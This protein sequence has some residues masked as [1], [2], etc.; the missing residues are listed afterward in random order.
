MLHTYLGGHRMKNFNKIEPALK[1]AYL[2]I[3][4]DNTETVYEFIEV[5]REL[6]NSLNNP[7]LV[8]AERR[9]LTLA[10]YAAIAFYAKKIEAV[11]A[12]VKVG[13]PPQSKTFEQLL[14]TIGNDEAGI[15]DALEPALV[16]FRQYAL[17]DN[18]A[19][20][21]TKL[22]Q[23]ALLNSLL[24]SPPTI[25]EKE[26]VCYDA[27]FN[28]S[29]Q[30]QL[31]S[32]TFW[33]TVSIVGIPLAIFS[34]IAWGAV[35]LY[36]YV[37]EERV[38]QKNKAK[39]LE[40]STTETN[41]T[42]SENQSL[43][44]LDPQFPSAPKQLKELTIQNFDSALPLKAVKKLKTREELSQI[45]LSKSSQSYTLSKGK[46]P[47]AQSLLARFYMLSVSLEQN[48]DLHSKWREF[49]KEINLDSTDSSE[50][51]EVG[52]DNFEEIFFR[53]LDAGKITL[54]N[55]SKTEYFSILYRWINED[56]FKNRI[57]VNY[58]NLSNDVKNTAE[59]ALIAELKKLNPTDTFHINDI[60]IS[61]RE[62]KLFELLNLAKNKIPGL[63]SIFYNGQRIEIYKDETIFDFCFR[64][65]LN[66]AGN[67]E[68]KKQKVVE[69]F[70]INE[71]LH[72]S[73]P[74]NLDELPNDF[75]GYV[76]NNNNLFYLHNKYHKKIK[77]DPNTSQLDLIKQAI[78]NNNIPEN[79]NLNVNQLN[80]LKKIINKYAIRVVN[81]RN[82]KLGYFGDNQEIGKAKHVRFEEKLFGDS[83]VNK[84]TAQLPNLETITIKIKNKDFNIKKANGENVED[85]LGKINKI[86]S[87][88]QS[89][90][91]VKT[92]EDLLINLRLDKQDFT[93][94]K[95]FFIQPDAALHFSN[96]LEVAS[97][98]G[99]KI[100]YENLLN[101]TEKSNSLIQFLP[102]VRNFNHILFRKNFFTSLQEERISG[103]STKTFL[104]RVM[105]FLNSE[106]QGQ[107]ANN[108]LFP[109]NTIYF[110]K[111]KENF[112][113]VLDLYKKN[114]E[115]N[116]GYPI[117]KI[118]IGDDELNIED[119]DLKAIRVLK[120]F[121]THLKL[122]GYTFND[123]CLA[124]DD[125]GIP[126]SNLYKD[127]AE[128]HC[129]RLINGE[130]D[131]IFKD[132][133]FFNS[134]TQFDI[135]QYVVPQPHEFGKFGHISYLSTDQASVDSVTMGDAQSLENI[136]TKRKLDQL[137]TNAENSAELTFV[138]NI[139]K[140]TAG[141]VFSLHKPTNKAQIEGKII[142]IDLADF[143]D[144]DNHLLRLWINTEENEKYQMKFKFPAQFGQVQINWIEQLKLLPNL[145]SVTFGN[146]AEVLCN[147]T[148][149]LL[150]A[151]YLNAAS[152]DFKENIQSTFG[153]AKCY[154]IN[155]SNELVLSEKITDAQWAVLVDF[156]RKK[157]GEKTSLLIGENKV[158][159]RDS[160]KGIDR[161]LFKAS[162]ALLNV[163]KENARK[164][165]G[166][167][168]EFAFS[169]AAKADI[170]ANFKGYWQDS[171]FLY[172]LNKYSTEEILL[173]EVKP[174]NSSTPAEI[175]S[176]E[177][178]NENCVRK[179]TKESVGS[180]YFS[181]YQPVA[182]AKHISLSK[183]DFN[184]MRAELSKLTQLKSITFPLDEH[185][186]S[187]FRIGAD[188]AV[189][190][191]LDRVDA[192]IKNLPSAE[193]LSQLEGDP[194]LIDENSLPSLLY[195]KQKPRC[196]KIS[197][198]I[199]ENADRLK[200]LTQFLKENPAVS[201]D[202]NQP[203]KLLSFKLTALH[204]L[205]ISAENLVNE[206]TTTA[207]KNIHILQTI[208][209]TFSEKSGFSLNKLDYQRVENFVNQV[210][211]VGKFLQE[212]EEVTQITDDSENGRVDLSLANLA[213]LFHYTN[214]LKTIVLAQDILENKEACD[215]LL[216]WL[217]RNSGIEVSFEE[218]ANP[219]NINLFSGVLKNIEID[220]QKVMNIDF[221]SFNH[222]QKITLT[223]SGKNFVAVRAQQESSKDFSDRVKVIAKF[224]A[225]KNLDT[226][227]GVENEIS[228]TG[229]NLAS[230]LVSEK[231]FSSIELTNDFL[232]SEDPKYAFFAWLKQ[233]KKE[234]L[235]LRIEGDEK[236]YRIEENFSFSKLDLNKDNFIVGF[237]HND[238]AEEIF[239]DFSEIELVQLEKLGDFKNVKVFNY[240]NFD[241]EVNWEKLRL[242]LKKLDNL[243]EIIYYKGGDRSSFTRK[244]ENKMYK[245]SLDDFLSKA[246]LR[247]SGKD[248]KM[249]VGGYYQIDEENADVI[250]DKIQCSN[251]P[252]QI[253]LTEDFSKEKFGEVI[254]KL[255]KLH[256][257]D[258]IKFCDDTVLEKRK[259]GG[260]IESS[261]NFLLRVF[262]TRLSEDQNRLKKIEFLDLDR[263]EGRI[264][265]AKDNNIDST[266]LYL[267][268]SQKYCNSSKSKKL[269]VDMSN[270]NEKELELFKE[271][272]KSASEFKLEKVKF[273][274]E[275]TAYI[276]ELVD[277]KKVT[278]LELAWIPNN[279]DNKASVDLILKVFSEYDKESFI[280]FSQF[281]SSVF[282]GGNAEEIDGLEAVFKS[283][284]WL[285]LLPILAKQENLT[286]IGEHKKSPEEAHLAFLARVSLSYYGKDERKL[287]KVLN[288][289]EIDSPF[290]SKFDEVSLF[291][292]DRKSR[293]ITVSN[294]NF[295]WLLTDSNN[296]R[297]IKNIQITDNLEVYAS[298][299]VSKWVT[300]NNVKYPP[301]D[302]SS[303]TLKKRRFS[304]SD[305]NPSVTLFTESRE[306]TNS[307]D[308]EVKSKMKGAPTPSLMSLS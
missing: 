198:N 77:F 160:E 286:K 116:Q 268:L 123:I 106:A 295:Y 94:D 153:V 203:E 110:S 74:N 107:V 128:H 43:E 8:D 213:S 42:I 140:V 6:I 157:Y 129:F 148:T 186:H 138:G 305:L 166:L 76:I 279:I 202:F 105:L 171:G 195:S 111:N 98:K 120:F 137:I 22:L 7:Q 303:E 241:D 79:Q 124:M 87:S 100:D 80:S 113:R 3:N 68:N 97:D 86:C 154:S 170:D 118:V 289:L 206:K 130:T 152:D 183:D 194:V 267:L 180:G 65:A 28:Y 90:S 17:A 219:E 82:L 283:D 102:N 57:V 155:E 238:Q 182:S 81:E 69:N 58:E 285:N 4:K 73:F 101:S 260:K 253:H 291:V 158:E 294:Q 252:K 185:H 274:L 108:H 162:L 26:Q 287:K 218:N 234:R 239:I 32:F 261:R 143:S 88:S 161:L 115:K 245:E 304:V 15:A 131:F 293:S 145:V 262:S 122:L 200:V 150:L 92:V 215:A 250:I 188:E 41:L 301:S 232:K 135:S 211:T 18:S 136:L 207:L 300:D 192:A 144:L 141:K 231:E 288:A 270:F 11:N 296:S 59:D 48:A 172:Y 2:K 264:N 146:N 184:D 72:I 230:F 142:E 159:F 20:T 39:C 191:F 280:A 51:I 84:M 297:K 21:S 25:L 284:V 34:G 40:A 298:G 199:L 5:V 71:N 61:D 104:Y 196:I 19:D 277:T 47:V 119:N 176:F 67:D 302:S 223:D 242:F 62:D 83:F 147:G 134:I 197:D 89:V 163:D 307:L 174:T 278:S 12:Y 308:T 23:F 165:L 251:Q 254:N 299:V 175:N 190:A 306:R 266:N 225:D 221:A 168:T 187:I 237:F 233:N 258:K 46:K 133:A 271:W 214:K 36:Q 66:W 226:D 14:S 178:F 151:A 64:V 44:R 127:I 173:G 210:V 60:V 33:S 169:N 247:I 75:K 54:K 164:N 204:N 290:A 55:F 179:I 216:V 53:K 29:M 45:T 99:K 126:S 276:K 63:K 273:K 38:I 281:V 85:F 78:A 156:F 240:K 269:S 243:E 189:S 35:T 255:S 222:L 31:S 227:L 167:S 56:I 70:E 139:I 27:L 181:D 112:K 30:R 49:K 256:R 257:L 217:S 229:D 201:I 24:D 114:Q 103:E 96:Y 224:L 209:I 220:C 193:E 149:G 212:Q 292:A 13:N 205:S 265:L 95:A 282:D 121:H 9:K 177:T 244:K 117:N 50:N 1:G 228:L 37:K 249:L 246:S 235:T 236:E 259:E 93:F 109:S 10:L 16:Q 275:Q 52:D 208:R 263:A 272:H 125:L 91:T 248:T 132:A